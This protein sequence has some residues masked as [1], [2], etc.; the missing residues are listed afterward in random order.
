MPPSK[1]RCGSLQ[2]QSEHEHENATERSHAKEDIPLVG[3]SYTV[4]VNQL[5]NEDIVADVFMEKVHD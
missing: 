4:F 2:V 3:S 1:Q 5:D